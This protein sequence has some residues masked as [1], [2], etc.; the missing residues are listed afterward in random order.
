MNKYKIN[1]YINEYIYIFIKLVVSYASC[2]VS[3][4]VYI[5]LWKHGCDV[6]TDANMYQMQTWVSLGEFERPY[7]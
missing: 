2:D 4:C 1:K 5:R 3:C 6:T 7:M